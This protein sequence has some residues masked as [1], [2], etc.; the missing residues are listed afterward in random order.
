MKRASSVIAFIPFLAIS[1]F[2]GIP[3]MAQSEGGFRHIPS[4]AEIEAK[5]NLKEI[6]VDTIQLPKIDSTM[7][8]VRDVDEILAS[9]GKPDY[10]PLIKNRMFA[11]WVFSGY[12]KIVKKQLDPDELFK[13]K[14]L[15]V[16]NGDLIHADSIESIEKELINGT[17]TIRITT[18]TLVTDVMS[19]TRSLDINN[20][21]YTPQWLHD[22]LTANRI[23]DDIM[24]ESMVTNPYNIDYAYWDLPER[25]RLPEDDVSFEAYIRKLDLPDVDPEKAELMESELRKIYWL[26]KVN[27]GLQFS[28]A[29][30]SQNW[31][32]GGNNHLALLFNFNWN[33]QLNQVYYPNFLFQSNFSYKLGMNSTPQDEVHDYSISEDILQ[34]NL[35]AGLKAFKK[36]F[37]SFN[38]MFKTQ[39]LKN[40]EQNSTVRKASFLSPGDFNVGLGMSYSTQ[41]KKKTFQLTATVSPISYNLKTC[42]SDKVDHSRFNIEADKKTHSEIGSNGEINMT[43][44]LAWNIEYKSRLF[45][46]TDYKYFL[47]DWEHTLSFNINKFLSTQIYAHMRYDTSVPSNTSWKKFML[48]EVLSF[49]LSYTFSTKP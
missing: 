1:M 9:I 28:Q 34:Y 13:I 49:G 12:K 33:V 14:G 19:T 41:N 35:N 18:E 36:W 23:Q 29:F 40:Y 25:P 11:P 8:I 45:L 31:Y 22:A 30:V 4:S 10:V 17:D 16:T 43:W 44:K 46:F 7:F 26:H 15:S 37:Y 2:S 6:V 24:Y 47:S 38:M 27:T 5:I 20:L 42:I 21:S 39:L 3:A 48:R 32:Q